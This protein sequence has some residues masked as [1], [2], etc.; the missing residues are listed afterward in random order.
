MLWNS[1]NSST[2]QGKLEEAAP[3]YKRAVAVWEKALGPDHPQVATG[4]NNQAL[5]LKK[6]V[7]VVDASCMLLWVLLSLH[8]EAGLLKQMVSCCCGFVCA[9]EHVSV[10]RNSQ[11][12]PPRTQGKP[13]D[14]L[15]LYTRSREIFEKVLGQDHPNVATLLN[16]EAELLREM[17][18]CCVGC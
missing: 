18:G 7:R 2:A 8:H 15:P 16:N 9:V 10:L 14:A 1:Q 6:M 11:T 13:E 3:L 17:V 12:P 4:L 5:L